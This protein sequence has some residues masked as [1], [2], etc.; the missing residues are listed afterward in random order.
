MGFYRQHLKITC[1]LCAPVHLDVGGLSHGKILP[2]NL[3]TSLNANLVNIFNSTQILECFFEYYTRKL[4][5]LL[6]FQHANCVR[7]ILQH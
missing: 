3:K 1:K 2:L 6:Q 7:Y 4:N 5:V